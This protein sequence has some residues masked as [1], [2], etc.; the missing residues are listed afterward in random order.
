MIFFFCRIDYIAIFYDI[1]VS[2]LPFLNIYIPFWNIHISPVCALPS[3][4]Y[5]LPRSPYPPSSPPFLWPAYGVQHSPC[6]VSVM[7]RTLSSTNKALCNCDTPLSNINQ[8]SPR[9]HIYPIYSFYIFK[10]VARL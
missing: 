4:I 2:V 10:Q 6:L 9:V 1:Y 5:S 8:H 7:N 3:A